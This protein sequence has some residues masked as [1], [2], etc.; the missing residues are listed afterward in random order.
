MLP[1]GALGL[2]FG[3]T[4]ATPKPQAAII[5]YNGVHWIPDQRVGTTPHVGLPL[6][7]GS[8]N[9][10]EWTSCWRFPEETHATLAPPSPNRI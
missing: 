6:H 3:K 7:P 9:C 8:E 5:P 10:I 4:V 2:L 1:L